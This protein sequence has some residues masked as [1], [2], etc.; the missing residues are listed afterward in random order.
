[1]SLLLVGL[2]ILFTRGF[3]S[4]KAENLA[5][6]QDISSITQK[7]EEVKIAY[8]M[9]IEQF[10]NELNSSFE[11]EK[12]LIEAR[13]ELYK[14]AVEL[15]KLIREGENNLIKNGDVFNLISDKLIN[16]LLLAS[17][18]KY[19]H[20]V[21]Q[22]EIAVLTQEYN[23]QAEKRVSASLNEPGKKLEIN[24]TS[25]VEALERIQLKLLNKL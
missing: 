7:V 19:L 22:A 24:Y 21:L 9:K 20:D 12:T 23:T 15:R 4:K 25:I 14:L 6:K 13:V 1:M 5:T 3:V 17:S 11:M 18:H 16:F 10:K 8:I 2:F